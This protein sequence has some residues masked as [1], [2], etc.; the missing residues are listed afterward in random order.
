MRISRRFFGSMVGSGGLVLAF[1]S[2]ALAADP[3][4]MNAPALNQ[5]DTAIFARMPQLVADGATQILG[6]PNGDVTII[7]F[8]DYQCPYSRRVQERLAPFVRQDGNVKLVVKN[9][10]VI[11]PGSRIAARAARAAALQDKF[12]Q[13]HYLLFETRV[14]FTKDNLLKVAA[15]VGIDPVKLS[16]DMDTINVA[17]DVTINYDQ[18]RQIKVTSTPTFII[19]GHLVTEASAD[20]DFPKAIA[21]ARASH[22]KNSRPSISNSA[23]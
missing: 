16:R 2:H 5:T 17:D 19:D 23:N 11:G 12:E 21:A 10:P 9:F 22:G 6:N 15:D 4:P 1:S 20:I 7:E 18:A 8:F 13:F 3:A 14:A